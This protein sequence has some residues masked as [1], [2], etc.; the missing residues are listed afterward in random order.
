MI[1]LI[2]AQQYRTRRDIASYIAIMVGLLI[3]SMTALLSM[4]DEGSSNADAGHFFLMS[5]GGFAIISSLIILT[6][7]GMISGSDMLD[8]TMN[9]EI[10]DG[11]KRSRVYFSRFI[12][13]LCWGVS[14]MYAVVII[15]MIVTGIIKGWGN[16]ISVGQFA[17]R[18]ALL[19]FPFVRITALY[20]AMTF[21]L[22]DFRAVF[23][24][25]YILSETELLV[26]FVFLEIVKV[27]VY[28]RSLF[29]VPAVNVL[30][31]VN[32]I[33]FDYVNAEDIQVVKNTLSA[34]ECVICVGI[35]I[36]MTVLLLVLGLKIFK[37]KDLK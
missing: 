8:K 5:A 9:F 22:G 21:M 35:N 31:D 10:L 25:G 13:S 15:P 20:T 26:E 18:M 29:S 24:I 14:V 2:K 16:I 12:V 17:Q 3:F 30:L 36:V 34:S 37:N 33:G 27:P 6:F 19:L 23:A 1:N 11:A 32:N 7:T 28:V 4:S